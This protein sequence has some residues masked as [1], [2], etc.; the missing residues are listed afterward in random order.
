MSGHIAS[1]RSYIL[2]FL[3]LIVGTAL[4]YAAALVD[5]GFF[6]NVVMLAIALAK[7]SL[8]ILFFM[9]VRWSSRLTWVVAASGFVWLLILFG[10]TMSDYLSRGWMVGSSALDADSGSQALGSR[11]AKIVECVVK[12][13]RAQSLNP[14]PLTPEPFT[15]PPPPL[16]AFD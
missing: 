10:I 16:T 11:L 4:T 5:F 6:N 3:A 12:L 14:E 7:A 13:A 2:V 9:G 1:T 15:A 8:V